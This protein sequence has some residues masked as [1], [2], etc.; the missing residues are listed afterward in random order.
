MNSIATQNNPITEKTKVFAENGTE[1]VKFD[2]MHIRIKPQGSKFIKAPAT[3]NSIP[4]YVLVVIYSNNILKVYINQKKTQVPP[5]NTQEML[6]LN[7]TQES[8]CSDAKDIVMLELSQ[9]AFNSYKKDNSDL[10]PDDR[11]WIS[12]LTKKGNYVHYQ[13]N[14]IDRATAIYQFRGKHQ[15]DTRYP[16]LTGKNN[17]VD[18]IHPHIRIEKAYPV[19]MFEYMMNNETVNF[20]KEEWNNY[21]FE[22]GSIIQ[23]KGKR[24]IM[25]LDSHGNY[26]YFATRSFK[27]FVFYGRFP[28]G[29]S[30]SSEITDMK[31]HGTSGY[32]VS[33]PKHFAFAQHLSPNYENH[34]VCIPGLTL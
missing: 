11:P 13:L 4:H 8:V 28:T 15:N 12:L 34:N 30:S 23:L 25:V 5:I 19:N 14:V 21:T 17:S 2:F 7:L 24:F 22:T 10:K 3:A 32:F 29:A 6:S 20:T 27:Q 16:E 18:Y 9:T 31:I 33:F 1:I 26:S